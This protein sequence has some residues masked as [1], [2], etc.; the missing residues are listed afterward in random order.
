[1]PCAANSDLAS[2]SSAGLRAEM[3][4]RAPISESPFAICSPRPRDP[5]VTSA[6]LP[7]SSN[8]SRTPMSYL[9]AFAGTIVIIVTQAP[10][11]GGSF[12]R[13]GGSREPPGADESHDQHLHDGRPANA[14]AGT[15]QQRAHHRAQERAFGHGDG[16]S[17]GADCD[18]HG[19][20]SNHPLV[21]RRRH[22]RCR[23]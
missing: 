10:S 12:S 3:A 2:A 8:K 14:E 18:A 6:T 19:T 16:E 9:L 15:L 7:P 20:A 11:N 23:H 5:P 21:I 13:G 22:A 1:M 4:M 17:G